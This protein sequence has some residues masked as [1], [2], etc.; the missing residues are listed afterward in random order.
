MTEGR[1]RPEEAEAERRHREEAADWWAGEA[2]HPWAADWWAGEVDRPSWE[3]EEVNP[4][5]KEEQREEAEEEER[6]LWAAEEQHPWTKVA[7]AE[8]RQKKTEPTAQLSDDRPLSPSWSYD[9]V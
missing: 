4:W 7:A 5:T 8:E 9:L 1:K 6:L 3:E 2:E